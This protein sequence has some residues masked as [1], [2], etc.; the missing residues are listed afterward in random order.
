MRLEE[1]RGSV[2]IVSAS[3]LGKLEEHSKE[4]EFAQR[5]CEE[6]QCKEWDSSACMDQTAQGGL[7]GCQSE[8]SR[9]QL[10]KKEDN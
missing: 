3:T 9:D 4:T 8:A 7:G 2:L 6:K 1:E 10:L 5:S